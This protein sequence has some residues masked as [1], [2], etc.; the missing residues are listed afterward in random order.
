MSDVESDLPPELDEIENVLENNSSISQ[1]NN[2]AMS[3]Q[4]EEISTLVEDASE[5]KVDIQ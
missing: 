4:E 5:Q 3:Q 2:S 1:Q